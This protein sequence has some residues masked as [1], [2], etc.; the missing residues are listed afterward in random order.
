MEKQELDTYKIPRVRVGTVFT[1]FGTAKIVCSTEPT[2]TKVRKR[3]MQNKTNVNAP[4]S[5]TPKA[6]LTQKSKI[7]HYIRNLFFVKIPEQELW[8]L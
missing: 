1:S 7:A 5:R 3:V 2:S 8:R 4:T 6:I